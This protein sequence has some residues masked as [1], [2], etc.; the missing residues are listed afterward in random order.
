M[1]YSDF[2]EKIIGCCFEVMRELGT[3]FWEKVYKNALFIAMKQKGLN[4]SV[5]QTFEVTF[6]NCKIGR[7]VADLIVEN[8]IV[9]EL[10]CCTTLLPEHKAQVINYLKASGMSVGLLVNFGQQK[11]E[12]KRL[13]HPSNVDGTEKLRR[14]FHALARSNE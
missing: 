10:K 11:L 4:V 14:D 9:V 13:R 6:R 1:L 5:E 12:Y 2:S 3:G 7:Y 8:V